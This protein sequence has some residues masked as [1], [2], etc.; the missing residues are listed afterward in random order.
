M[1]SEFI[2]KQNSDKILRRDFLRTSAF[3]VGVVYTFPLLFTH[4]TSLRDQI[5]M[6]NKYGL[7]GKLQ[8]KAGHGKKLSQLLMKDTDKLPG[9]ILYVVCRDPENP[10]S[11][12]VMEV[13]ETKE[14]HDNSLKLPHVRELISQAMPL[15]AEPPTG[16]INLD[17]LGGKGA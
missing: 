12:Y 5:K 15:I 1:L 17:V 11:I 13:W 10:D 8:A 4:Q 7:F 2:A 14:H 9:C 3:S 16:G 6:Q